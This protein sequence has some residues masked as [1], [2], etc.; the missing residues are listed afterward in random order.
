MKENDR[1]NNI[2]KKTHSDTWLSH[3]AKRPLGITLNKN[4]SKLGLG[5]L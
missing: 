1:R 2:A 4:S 3:T 5:F